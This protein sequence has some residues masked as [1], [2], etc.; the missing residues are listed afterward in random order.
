VV[1][2]QRDVLAALAQRRHLDRQHA[3]PVV[4]VLAEA[5]LG[6]PVAQVAVGRRDHAHIDAPGHRAADALELALLQHAQQLGLQ[7]R[8]DLADLVE[9]QRAAVGQLEAALAHPVGAGERAL[10]VAEQLA[11]EQGRRTGRRSSRTA[12][13]ARRAGGRAWIA[14]AISSL[15]VPL[16]P[17][18]STVAELCATRCTFSSTG[19]IAGDWPISSRWRV[20]VLDR[21][22]A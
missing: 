2:Q 19:C 8:R 3:E 9:Q 13:A 1:H 14:R 6:G 22:G 15:P 16:S 17:V 18:I 20:Q 4:Q 5:R 12:S 10:L 7:G 21:R 11:L